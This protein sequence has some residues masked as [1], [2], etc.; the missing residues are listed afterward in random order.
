MARNVKKRLYKRV[1]TPKRHT[2]GYIATG[3]EFITVKQA[4]Q[5]TKND[6]ISGVRVVG[7]HIQAEI[8]SQPLYRLPEIVESD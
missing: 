2:K 5:Q 1:V 3:G 7:K 4:L 8:G 6:L